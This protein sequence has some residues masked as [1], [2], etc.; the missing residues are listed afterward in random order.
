MLAPSTSDR[1]HGHTMNAVRW[2]A[3]LIGGAFTGVLSALP[4]ISVV[5]LCCCLWVVGGGAVT[6]YLTQQGQ[7]QPLQLI[8]AAVGGFLAGVTGAFVYAVVMVPIQLAT[9][10]FQ[11]GL[12]DLF[13]SQDVPPE[14]LE[15]LEQLSTS[16]LWAVVFGFMAMLFAG[17]IFSTVGGVI[18]ALIFRREASPPPPG[19]VEVLP[20]DPPSS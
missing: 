10:P 5:N 13:D 12:T 19:T 11:R 9:A 6:A 7:P 4:L 18:G 20:P 3:V 14:M 17:M 8:D 16:S 2:Q 15:M 1:H